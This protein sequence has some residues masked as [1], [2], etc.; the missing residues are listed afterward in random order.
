MDLVIGVDFDNTLVSYDDLMCRVAGERG[1]VE[2]GTKATK[3]VLRDGI[4][5]LPDGE[6]EWQKLQAQVY[7][8]QMAD[9]RLI[10]GVKDFFQACK[11][12][13]VSVRIVSHKSERANADPTVTNLR[14]A[15]TEWIISKGFFDPS[16][17]GLSRSQVY[18]EST[19]YEKIERI[20]N[21]GCTHFID[22]LKEV[23]LEETFPANVRKL[24]F[25]PGREESTLE[26]G[27]VFSSWKEL[28]E[29]FFQR[30]G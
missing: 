25:C 3:T 17:M 10:E 18:F 2:P 7:G 8:P 12:K 1:L 15:A 6:Q 5:N 26:G 28:S 4:R 23:F 29:Y 22:D 13:E 9:A 14:G 20:R 11:E 30:R 19:R 21:L 27:T 24:L 16:G